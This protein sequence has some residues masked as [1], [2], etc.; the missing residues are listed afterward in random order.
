LT[1]LN[2][3]NRIERF[4]NKAVSA[5]HY[6]SPFLK[7]RGSCA[8]MSLLFFYKEP[9]EDRDDFSVTSIIMRISLGRYPSGQR[10]QTVNLLAYVFQGSNPCLPTKTGSR[11]VL[12]SEC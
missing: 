8:W 2:F 3:I 4:L 11:Q 1:S 12:S 9:K 5:A 10:G 6:F 7:E